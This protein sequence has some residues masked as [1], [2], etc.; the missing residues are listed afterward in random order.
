LNDFQRK[1]KSL[2]YYNRIQT[3]LCI[4]FCFYITSKIDFASSFQATLTASKH[5]GIQLFSNTFT[6]RFHFWHQLTIFV[7]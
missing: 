1:D 5:S 3:F 7:Q 2:P 6:I 4:V